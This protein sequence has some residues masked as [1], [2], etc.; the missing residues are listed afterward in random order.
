VARFFFTL[1][2]GAPQDQGA[3][4]DLPNL[5]S[6]RQHAARLLGERLTA[7]PGAFWEADE[8]RVDVT[9]NSGLLLFTIHCAGVVAPAGR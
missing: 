7:S 3:G 6:A 1:D 5:E 9:N 8:W 2:G 4:V